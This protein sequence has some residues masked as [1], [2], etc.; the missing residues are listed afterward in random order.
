MKKSNK[1]ELFRPVYLS[2]AQMSAKLADPTF[3]FCEMGR[4]S[5]KT[6][7]IMAPRL[8]RVQNAMPGS[9]I[10]L[11]ASTYKSI[12]TNILPNLMEYFYENY[13]QGIYFELGQHPPAHFQKCGTKIT[14]WKN[15]ISFVNGSVVQFVSC[16]RPESMVGL[17][18]VHIFVDE[19][20]RI[21]GDKFTERILPALRSNRAKYGHSEYL[22]EFPVF[23]PHR[24]LKPIMTGF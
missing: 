6:T 20:L 1:E 7:H 22:W 15:T 16:D 9:L 13:E 11:V 4:G 21:N 24:I 2:I 17:N 18:T 8:D 10:I 12:F 23:L 19:M 14:D 5:G 3:L